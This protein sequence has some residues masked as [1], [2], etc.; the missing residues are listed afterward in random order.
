MSS[1]SDE[2][3][4]VEL[5]S[6]QFFR[7]RSGSSSFSQPKAKEETNKTTTTVKKNVAETAFE[8]ISDDDFEISSSAPARVAPAK[9]TGKRRIIK[10][11]ELS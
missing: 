10:K 3:S 8:I 1:E 5:L 2:D 9:P 11:G 4:D 6:T 7:P